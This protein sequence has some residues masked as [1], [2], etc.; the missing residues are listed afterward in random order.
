MTGDAAQVLKAT[1][2]DQSGLCCQ[3]NIVLGGAPGPVSGT[4][5]LVGICVPFACDPHVLLH[6]AS[7]GGRRQS[8]L[9][10]NRIVVGNCPSCSV[11]EI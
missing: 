3:V 9:T 1:V 6:L 8:R 11:R 10:S 2:Q 5:S 7:L 4:Y